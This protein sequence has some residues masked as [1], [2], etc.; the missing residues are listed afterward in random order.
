MPAGYLSSDGAESSP[1][2]AYQGQVAMGVWITK[3]WV[4]SNSELQH[5]RM[6]HSLEVFLDSQILLDEQVA[7]VARK[8]FAQ[9]HLVHQFYTLLY[10]GEGDTHALITSE[11]DCCNACYMGLVFLSRALIL[12]ESMPLYLLSI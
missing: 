9:F 3:I 5:P 12:L 6:V 4:Y 2:Q 11:L 7:D 1:T 10:W 8:V